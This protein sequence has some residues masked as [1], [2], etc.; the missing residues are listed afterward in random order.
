[1]TKILVDKAVLEQ[2]LETLEPRTHSVRVADE[3]ADYKRTKAA[4]TALRAA[5]AQEEQKPL[6]ADALAREL[7]TSRIIDPAAI[8][9]PVGYDGG[10][11]LARVLDLHRRLAALEQEEQEPVAWMVTDKDGRHFIFRMNKPVISE[12]ETL[13]PLYTHPPRIEQLGLVNIA[14]Q[15]AALADGLEAGN[16]SAEEAA[17]RLA[18]VAKGVV[19]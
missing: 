6:S 13:T 7:V 16:S 17:A 11:T 14:R 19:G 5:L 15:L 18:R 10:M 9:D 2:A 8:D 3:G 1:M 4:I 12:G